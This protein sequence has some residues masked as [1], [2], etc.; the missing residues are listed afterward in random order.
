MF[1][2]EFEPLNHF[3]PLS[4]K[5][6]GEKKIKPHCAGTLRWRGST[7]WG[8][9]LAH[10]DITSCFSRKAHRLISSHMCQCPAGRLWSWLPTALLPPKGQIQVK[11]I[12]S[13]TL[14]PLNPFCQKGEMLLAALW[15]LWPVPW[16]LKRR[17]NTPVNRTNGKTSSGTALKQRVIWKYQVRVR[18]VSAFIPLFP[19]LWP[20]LAVKAMLPGNS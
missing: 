6:M 9:L 7:P 12:I 11:A 17:N 14:K 3:L 13:L 2:W 19:S 10:T 15:P 20:F 8:Q 5:L 1:R 4:S 18:P 16:G